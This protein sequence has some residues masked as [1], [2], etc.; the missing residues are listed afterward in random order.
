MNKI[1]KSLDEVRGQH[2]ARQ[3]SKNVLSVMRQTIPEATT[4]FREVSQKLVQ[5]LDSEDFIMASQAAEHAG[6]GYKFM[7]R[8]LQTQQQILEQS[9]FQKGRTPS[10]DELVV[11]NRL[12]RQPLAEGLSEVRQA[13]RRNPEAVN[14]GDMARLLRTSLASKQQR[15][16]Q[17]ASELEDT[18][19][20]V[21]EEVLSAEQQSPQVLAAVASSYTS[22]SEGFLET[23]RSVVDAS[24]LR[25]KAQAGLI[26]DHAL[27]TTAELPGLLMNER[28]EDQRRLASNSRSDMRL[29]QGA[30]SQVMDELK[31]R[32]S[33]DMFKSMLKDA[34]ANGTAER[35]LTQTLLSVKRG[36]AD[37]L[38]EVN[39]KNGWQSD[40]RGHVV[41]EF[42]V[43]GMLADERSHADLVDDTLPAEAMVSSFMHQVEQTLNKQATDRVNFLAEQH[44]MMANLA[45]ARQ[46]QTRTPDLSVE[47]SIGKGFPPT[48]VNELTKVARHM[49]A[50]VGDRFDPTLGAARSRSSINMDYV[51]Q[52]LGSSEPEVR[53][54]RSYTA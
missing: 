24:A 43:K 44:P 4:R 53:R 10:A 6:L 45:Q 2:Q 18:W 17:W 34:Q 22:G 41:N 27:P 37:T 15:L 3:E 8:W 49:E 1:F 13:I 31:K 7:E 19:P 52:T 39:L 42:V 12:Y 36:V 29:A 26:P 54:T 38:G 16:G 14:P 23:L 5:E 33:T 9:L 48:F 47:R 35:F 21:R 46:G 40:T 51:N 11:Y 30:I 20:G 50:E 25:Q 28:E 32:C